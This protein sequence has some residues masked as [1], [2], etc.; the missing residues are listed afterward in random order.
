MLSLVLILVITK[1]PND[2]E[3]DEKAV[4]FITLLKKNFR[5]F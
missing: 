1:R 5:A 3:A 4:E 2:T